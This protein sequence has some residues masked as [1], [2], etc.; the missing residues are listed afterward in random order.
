MRVESYTEEGVYGLGSVGEEG[1]EGG[2]CHGFGLMA[3]ER[4]GK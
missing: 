4:E 2:V 1:E 3:G